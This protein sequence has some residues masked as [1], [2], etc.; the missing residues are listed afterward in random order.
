L[1]TGHLVHKSP[2]HFGYDVGAATLLCLAFGP[3]PSLFRMPFAISLA[4][5]ALLP[6]MQ[7]YYGLSALLHAWVVA[8]AA[9]RI[10]AGRGLE[11]RLAAALVCGTLAKAALE[12]SAGRSLFTGDLDFGGPVLHASH[13][14]GAALGLLAW[15]LALARRRVRARRLRR[16]T[17]TTPADPALR[18]ARPA[19]RVRLGP[20]AAERLSPPSSRRSSRSS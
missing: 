18:G 6:S 9:E 17:G 5:L 1:W 13:L 11:S 4:L 15:A 20:P 7:H 16:S 3:S 14:I 2:T 19:N 8:V 12:T 10:E